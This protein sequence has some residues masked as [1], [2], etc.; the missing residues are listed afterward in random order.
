MISA[1]FR[2]WY[3][4]GWFDQIKKVGSHLQST[5]DSFSIGQLL[6]TLFSPFRQI[7]AH[8]SGRSLD[9]KLAAFANRLI[10]RFVGFFIRFFTIITG[11]IVL[12]VLTIIGAVRIAGWLVLPFTP[13]IYMILS[14]VGVLPWI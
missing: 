12:L 13:L 10:S 7:S 9:A 5:S 1:F 2:W 4:E 6:S 3:V 14:V 8:D 11:L